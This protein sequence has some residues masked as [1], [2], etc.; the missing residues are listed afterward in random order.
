MIYYIRDEE[1]SLIGL[2]YNDTMYYYIKNMQEDIIGIT[3]SNNNLLCSYLYDSWGNIISI[4]D[5]DGNIINDT[6][7]IGIINPYRYRSYY[8]DSETKLYYLNSRYYNPEWGRFINAD[9]EIALDTNI[10]LNVYEYAFNNPISFEDDNG[11][12]PSWKSI[13]K[14]A[15]G[16]AVTVA[17]GAIAAVASGAVG[18]V[19]GAAFVG[20]LVGGAIGATAGAVNAAINN[21]SIIDGVANGYLFGVLTG[22]IVKG[23]VSTLNISRGKTEISGSPHGTKLHRLASNVEAGQMSVSGNYSSIG[24][25]RSLNSM[26]LNG[27]KRPDVIGISKRG[28]DKIIEVISPKQSKRYIVNKVKNIVN[29]NKNVEGKIINWVKR[30]SNIFR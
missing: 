29:N 6:S 9:E 4:K 30:I 26:G 11:D 10:G 16:V 12:W 7:H 23:T 24:L 8:Y 2:K 15:A 27:T 5:N 25:N 21:K 18:V 28:S 14:A 22:V 17:T 1:G 13:A 3:D 20:S 19:A